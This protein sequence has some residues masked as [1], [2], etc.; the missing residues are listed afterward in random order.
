MCEPEDAFL[1]GV[2]RPLSS[3]LSTT[4]VYT[5]SEDHLEQP[6]NLSRLGVQINIIVPW[7][8][9]EPRHGAHVAHQR[10]DKARSRRQTHIA[11][12]QCE[13]SRETLFDG[14][15]SKRES[16]LGHSEWHSTVALRFVPVHFDLRL[17][18]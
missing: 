1:L 2:Y 18:R 12:G 15:V 14:V 8:C 17:F 13:T 7:P 6:L 3:S 5:V 16:R 9:R 4:Y 10:E 11:D